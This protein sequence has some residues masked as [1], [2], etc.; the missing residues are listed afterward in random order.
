MKW[1]L[2]KGGKITPQVWQYLKQKKLI[3]NYQYWQLSTST[4]MKRLYC[5]KFFS[6]IIQP[7]SKIKSKP[8]C[9]RNYYLQASL[10]CSVHQ[11]ALLSLQGLRTHGEAV[12]SSE[13]PEENTSF[14]VSEFQSSS[15][16]FF[17]GKSERSDLEYLSEHLNWKD[18][19]NH[20]LKTQ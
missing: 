19:P 8:N 3:N 4:D 18:P 5:E 9:R 15:I 13:L 10:G 1:K 14:R 16:F 11:V 7:N 2:W 12:R 6:H 20:H 17:S